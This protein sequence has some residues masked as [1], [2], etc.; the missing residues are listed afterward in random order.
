MR[1]IA[2]L[3]AI[4]AMT[5]A[6][7]ASAQET[8]KI[9]VR[10]EE[11]AG[12]K[13]SVREIDKT[14]QKSR[15]TDASKKVLEDLDEQ[16]ERMD[17][18]EETILAKEPGKRP[19]RLSRK[20]EKVLVKE[21]GKIVELPLAGK[22]VTIERKDGKF[23]F[24]IDEGELSEQVLKYLSESFKHDT[25]DEEKFDAIFL[26]KDAVK[27]GETWKCDAKQIWKELMP[28][29]GEID[30]DKSTA[31][32]KL[33]EVYQKDGRTFGKIAIDVNLPLTVIDKGDEAKKR[34]RARSP[35]Q[36]R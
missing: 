22:T 27:V 3:A 34:R 12:E 2:I 17:V 26:S 5:A 4:V 32:G 7:V 14:T 21:E 13:Y 1:R 23:S 9:R 31:T 28:N 36:S 20:F 6:H 15:V 24:K 19:H 18:Y 10:K 35:E 33:T 30:A 29:A 16:T 25:D 8:Y 11:K